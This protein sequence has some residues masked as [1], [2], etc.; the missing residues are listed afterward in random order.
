MPATERGY[1]WH[2]AHGGWRVSRATELT[3]VDFL[4]AGKRHAS[5]RE[6]WCVKSPICPLRRPYGIHNMSAGGWVRPRCLKFMVA[7]WIE[8]KLKWQ[9]GHCGCKTNNQ[10]N[11]INKQKA[12][13]QVIKT[14]M[15]TYDYIDC[16]VCHVTRIEMCNLST[17]YINS[18]GANH[19][20]GRPRNLVN[21]YIEVAFLAPQKLEVAFFLHPC[22]KVTSIVITPNYT[23]RVTKITL[24]D[25]FTPNS[26]DP[27][28][29]FFSVDNLAKS[30]G[31]HSP[32]PCGKA[33]QVL[34]CLGVVFLVIFS[35]AFAISGMTRE[36]K[37]VGGA[38]RLGGI[39]Y[40]LG[41]PGEARI[42]SWQR[43][44]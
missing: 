40:T 8:M 23:P 20:L 9:Q 25:P 16:R 22:G 21:G 14:A 36:A 44:V 10:V 26:L 38:E 31:T 6:N 12:T 34:L 17:M 32:S 42:L 39:R 4:G 43:K 11:E 7:S 33:S 3:P 1:P 41:V 29:V 28:L 30:P 2:K 15:T 13:S 35:F 27:P 5:I 37:R 18:F 24:S 19:L